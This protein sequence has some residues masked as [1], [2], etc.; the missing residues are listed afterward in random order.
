LVFEELSPQKFEYLIKELACTP[1]ELAI[2]F[3]E[4]NK[5]AKQQF[6]EAHERAFVEE[7]PK[8]ATEMVNSFMKEVSVRIQSE[9]KPLRIRSPKGELLASVPV[10]KDGRTEFIDSII[11]ESN[12]ALRN[13]MGADKRG[14]SSPD[15]DLT[16]LPHHYPRLHP[17]WRDAKRLFKQN[18]KLN[19]WV[20]IIKAA[21]P[22][23]NDDL[24]LQ[25]SYPS[26][27]IPDGIFDAIAKTK[28]TAKPSDI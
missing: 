4:K 9:L 11:A 3:F 24:I 14:G 5:Q 6:I 18:K 2:K 20:Q 13:R 27:D 10:K 23:L 7:L 12:K 21:Y 8:K 16:E 17:I 26:A 15:F 25:L 22:Q 28:S 1:Q 19:S